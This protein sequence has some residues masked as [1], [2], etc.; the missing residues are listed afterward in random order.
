MFTLF[1]RIDREIKNLIFLRMQHA[2]RHSSNHFRQNHEI[3]RVARRRAKAS[4][5]YPLDSRGKSNPCKKKV[6]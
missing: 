3:S 1:C 6:K 4:A 2:A 5:S